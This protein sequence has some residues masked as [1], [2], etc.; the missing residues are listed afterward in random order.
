M[1]LVL[2]NGVYHWRQII[3]GQKF[4]RSTGTGILREAERTAAIWAGEATH[5]IV[6]KGHKPMLLHSVIKAF[7]EERKGAGG[8]SNARMHLSHFL[9]L[10][11]LKFSDVPLD[12]LQGV[13]TA[14]REAGIAHNTIMVQISYWN[15]VVAFARK[16]KFGEG[17][18]LPRME[19]LKT[20]L[21][22]LTPQE[23][24]ALFAA[25]DPKAY[26]PGKCDRT[27]KARQDNYD[28]LLMLLHLGCRYKEGAGMRWSQ[29]DLQNKRVMITRC[30]GGVDGTL[31]I[32]DKLHAML[33]RRF[34]ERTD[35]W[36]FPT[37]RIHNNNY[38]WIHEAC[39]R[40]GFDE[41]KGKFTLHGLRHTFATRML[42]A[43]MTLLEVKQLLGH[44]NIQST[45]V[46]THVEAGAVAEK[47][48][49]LLNGTTG[50]VAAV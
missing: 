8:Y 38:V 2:R 13:I 45:M 31:F 36:V 16:H 41:A 22:W 7:L 9:K 30:K 46:Y 32:S 37:K 1:A 39:K 17:T 33:T 44:K 20:K 12:K 14:R 4:S 48:V 24:A 47:A 15:A 10:D 28:L 40:A 25:I 21:R 11:N 6:V 3:R 35:E 50:H 27:D 26:Y 43:G 5:D 19:P 49:K 18:M 42:G 29:I 34:A 23:E